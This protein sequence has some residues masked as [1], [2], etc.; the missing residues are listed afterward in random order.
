MRIRIQGLGFSDFGFGELQGRADYVEER[1]SLAAKLKLLILR[2]VE[3][4]A[5]L[6]PSC[7]RRRARE[8]PEAPFREVSVSRGS[9]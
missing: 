7:F 3:I 1:L 6:S 9:G 5:S 2:L 4:N 8:P